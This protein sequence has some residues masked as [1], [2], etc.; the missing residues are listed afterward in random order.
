MYLQEIYFH[1]K[2]ATETNSASI[3]EYFTRVNWNRRRLPMDATSSWT[4]DHTAYFDPR[5]GI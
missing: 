2:K 3:F 4:G 1:L 5:T